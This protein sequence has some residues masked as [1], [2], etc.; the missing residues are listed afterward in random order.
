MSDT[1]F[2][3]GNG[4]SLRGFDLTRIDAREALG[5][6]AA[7]RFWREIG[8][9]P[10]HYCCLDD[11]MI[12]THHAQIDRL[13]AE[14]HVGAFFL[15]GRFFELHPDRIGNP[16]FLSFDQVSPYWHNARGKRMGLAF[17]EHPAFRTSDTEKV[18]TG[19][20]AVRYMAHKGF[21]RI[22]LMG[23]DL[24][25]VEI[26]PEARPTEGVGLVMAETPATN[27]NYFFDSYQQEGDR[28]NIPNPAVHA[29]R[30]H[31]RS[32][33][34]V[35]DDFAANEVAAEVVNT[36]P[37]SLLAEAGLFPQMQVETLL[38]SADARP[39]LGAV[40]VPC[41]Q[42]DVA[43]II[44][45]LHLWS[46]PSYAPVTEQPD[47]KPVL[48]LVFNNSGAK[49]H[50]APIES[51]FAQLPVRQAFARLEIAYLDLEGARDAYVRSH[52]VTDSEHGYK[53]GPNNLF[54]GAMAL[55]RR[56]GHYAFL[57]EAD[58]VPVRAGWLNYLQ[59]MVAG[60]DMFWVAGSAYR[61]NDRLGKE[62]ARHINGNAIYSCGDPAFQ[63][64]LESIWR[65]TLQ[66]VIRARNPRAAYDFV[67]DY[68]QEGIRS[69]LGDN[70]PWDFWRRHAHLFRYTDYVVN[71]SGNADLYDPQPD[72]VLR[73]LNSPTT[74]IVH[75]GALALAARQ[76]QES[77]EI[78][79]PA[80]LKPVPVGA[81]PYRRPLILRLVPAPLRRLLRRPFLALPERIQN[82]VR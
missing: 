81:P 69:D 72:M 28:F 34:L 33:E 46:D 44:A 11:Q 31:L 5:M 32:F 3:I 27:P 75:S 19:A 66:K 45:N 71:V 39:R 25:Y 7:Y 68:L 54:F 21:A 67:L 23:I 30:L 80:M 20:Y 59:A 38:A 77:G 64:F 78:P 26:L 4:P 12:E 16:A 42:G 65:P 57:M 15:H 52:E 13:Y 51:A 9:Y 41:T 55:A 50:I 18:T 49:E 70:A 62:I 29:G 40:V 47:E 48:A 76:A 6:N 17:E 74:F 1:C 24:R 58:C 73:A 63:S 61:G 2:V 37:A 60:P 36:N 10:Y 82:L 79:S 35:R 56:F 14:G 43:Q 22:A 8:W 53:A